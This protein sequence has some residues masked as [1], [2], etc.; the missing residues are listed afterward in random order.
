[1]RRRLRFGALVGSWVGHS[2]VW[3]VE[4]RAQQA[5]NPKVRFLCGSDLASIVSF[6]QR[7]CSSSLLRLRRTIHT[8]VQTRDLGQSAVGSVGRPFQVDQ[9]EPNH[10]AGETFQV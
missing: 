5:S 1:M 10:A 4:A 3:E 2:S 9:T 7:F 8:Q 6:D